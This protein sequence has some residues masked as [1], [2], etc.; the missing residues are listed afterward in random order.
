MDIS[1]KGS[2]FGNLAKKQE[3]GFE[4]E[5]GCFVSGKQIKRALAAFFRRKSSPQGIIPVEML[6]FKG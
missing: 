3:N 4:K 1:P 5:P 2:C 6:Y